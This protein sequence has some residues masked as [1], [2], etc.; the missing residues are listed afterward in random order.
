MAG[1]S[2]LEEAWGAAS[3]A[4]TEL[5]GYSFDD[6]DCKEAVEK[7]RARDPQ[8]SFGYVITPNV[9][10]IVRLR[11][12]IQV[13]EVHQAYRA[14]EM[15]LCDSKIMSLLARRHGVRLTVAAGSD[16][17]AGLM[18]AERGST[19]PIVVIG[20]DPETI[21]ILAERYG[22]TDLRQHIP[23]YGLMENEAALNEAAAFIVENSA[24]FAFIAVGSPQQEIIAYRAMQ[25]GS[26]TGLGLCIGA[27]I[28]FLTGRQR[29][30]PALMRVLALEWL[31]RLIR[32]PRRLWRRYLIRSPRIFRLLDNKAKRD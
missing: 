28:D 8:A 22:L 21:E 14:A 25:S 19:Y 9:D 12:E 26:A 31:Y 13:E 18:E 4:R 20:G 10:H 2:S 29:R 7:M 30:A 23:P 15:T 24:R 27:S 32:N 17:T 3:A 6:L 16:V 5:L 11:T 1:I